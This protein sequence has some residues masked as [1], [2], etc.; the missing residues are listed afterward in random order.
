MIVEQIQS[1]KAVSAQTIRLLRA[2]LQ[3]ACQQA[4]SCS[5]AGHV[6]GLQK[7][8]LNIYK[9][10]CRH[11]ALHQSCGRSISRRGNQS[12][13]KLQHYG[14][15]QQVDGSTGN[16]SSAG[17]GEPVNGF[18][19]DEACWYIEG[20]LYMLYHQHE[21]SWKDELKMCTRRSRRP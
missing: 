16:E 1:R 9:R 21:P 10:R 15:H 20:H 5:N 3:S 4:G 11:S 8:L 19:S 14:V 13:K 17:P 2:E 6:K 18:K 12:V 7:Q